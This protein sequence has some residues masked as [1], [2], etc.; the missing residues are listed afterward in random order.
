MKNKNS[1]NESNAYVAQYFAWLFMSVA[2]F[3]LKAIYDFP[4]FCCYFLNNSE[5]AIVLQF[6][7][8]YLSFRFSKKFSANLI[9][10]DYQNVYFQEVNSSG[11]QKHQF[12][13]SAQGTSWFGMET[14]QYLRSY[15][16]I[17]FCK[18]NIISQTNISHI[19]PKIQIHFQIEDTKNIVN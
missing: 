12:I 14:P 19:P 18:R 4:L 9:V 8:I 11:C 3:Q 17:F 2:F 10:S 6:C 5:K 13:S 16:F 7:K 1:C 15:L